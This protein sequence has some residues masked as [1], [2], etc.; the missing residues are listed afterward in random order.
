MFKRT[1]LATAVGTALLMGAAVS[2]NA[3]T[4]TAGNYKITLDNYDSGTT[5]YDTAIPG[6]VCSSVIGAKAGTT[7]L[8][9]DFHPRCVAGHR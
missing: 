3:L 7:L 8:Q 5:G 4:I 2:A 9:Q 6:A 1:F